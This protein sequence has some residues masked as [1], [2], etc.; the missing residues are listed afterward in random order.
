MTA[1]FWFELGTVA[2]FLAAAAASIHAIRLKREA[3]SA[4]LWLFLIWSFPFAGAAVYVVFGIDRIADH[5]MRRAAAHGAFCGERGARAEDPLAMAYWRRVREEQAIAPSSEEAAALHRAMDA[6]LPDF[7]LLGGN[8]I[9]LLVTGEEAYP[10][11]LDAIRA[12]RHHVHLQTFI[13][14]NDPVGR[15]F[16]DLLV[17]KASEG[18][19]VR[20]LYDRFGSTPAIVTG[21]LRRYRGRHPNLRLAGWTLAQ[22]L[23]RQFQVNLRNHRKILVVDGRIAFTG[24]LNLSGVN[25]TAD[26]RPPDR[27]VHFE[28]RGPAVHELQF[29]FLSDWH[30]MTAEPVDRLLRAE[31]F[32]SLVPEGSTPLRIV[33]GGPTLDGE[34]MSDVVFLLLAAARRRIVLVT[35]YFVPP[36]DI[37]RGLRAASLRGVD[38][39]LLVPQVNNHVYAGLAG[40]SYY[41]AVLAAGGRIFERAPP[42][43][44]TKALLI[45][46]GVAM[47]GTANLDS[48]SLRL[49]YETNLVAMDA[50]FTSRLDAAIGEEFRRAHEI[51]PADW[52]ARPARHQL[53]ER[54]CALLSPIL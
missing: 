39:R 10:R 48:R 45:D 34:V 21:F 29:S 42:F 26:G 24:G 9:D 14:A 37:L 32:P 54:A 31:L 53:L 2:H 17:D 52:A 40:R 6:L 33:N 13:L 11:M 18:V 16:M 41:G 43:M 50:R 44:H 38:V 25:A 5:A 4:L 51:R 36:P 30:F 49:N 1:A 7:P 20:L 23:R 47:V 46:D 15:R 35:P 12:A 22:P 3:S 28:V 19:E 8:R 27:D